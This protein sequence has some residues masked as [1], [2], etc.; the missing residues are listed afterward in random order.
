M[1]TTFFGK[2]IMHD[3]CHSYVRIITKI[4]IRLILPFEWGLKIMGLQM[5]R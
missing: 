2:V 1:I 3:V 5:F 4:A